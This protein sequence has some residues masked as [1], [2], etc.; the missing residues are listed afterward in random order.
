MANE[1]V[2]Q[3]PTVTNAMLSDIIYAVQGGVSVQ[4]TLQQVSN[5]ITANVVLNYPGNPNGNVAGI[6]FQF[7]WDTTDLVLY[8]CTTSG[9]AS[10]A[11]WTPA[12]SV[13]FPVGV[14]KGG[15]GLSSTTINQILYSSANNVIAGLATAASALLYTNSS[16]VPAMSSSMTNGQIMI[17]S[18]GASPV[19]ANVNAGPGVSI[20]NGEGTITISSTGS[21]V[22]WTEVTGTTQAMVPDGGYVTNNAGLVTLTLPVTAAFGTGISIIGKGVGGWTIVLNS[23]QT[24]QVGNLATTITSGSV[25]STNRYDSIDLICTTANTVW[26]TDGGA[27][28]NLTIV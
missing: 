18:T 7:C 2:T 17:G 5:L 27:Q 1:M 12:G 4:E 10:T 15:T 22:G 26:A 9:N 6:V 16:G 20:S 11:V 14:T 13:I 8:I 25:S 23:G 19:I 28:G 24:I 21:G 3:L